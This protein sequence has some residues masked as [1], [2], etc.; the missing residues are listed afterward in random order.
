MRRCWLFRQQRLEVPARPTG[1]LR[2]RS[3]VRPLKPSFMPANHASPKRCHFRLPNRQTHQRRHALKIFIGFAAWENLIDVAHAQVL[4]IPAAKVGGT[5]SPDRSTEDPFHC[6]ATEAFLHASEPCLTEALSFPAAKSTDASTPARFKSS[7]NGW[8]HFS[9]N[10]STAAAN[11]LQ[12][13]FRFWMQVRTA[14]QLFCKKSNNVWLLV[15]P[16]PQ[17]L[18]QLACECVL[19]SKLLFMSGNVEL[20]PGPTKED[21]SLFNKELLQLVK[22]LHDKFDSKHQEVMTALS[23]VKE[24]QYSMEQRIADIDN[25]LSAVEQ[26]IRTSEGQQGES[27]VPQVVVLNQRLNEFEDRSRRENLIFHG[28]ADSAAETWA[29]SEEKIC[30]VLNSALGM[31]LNKSDDRISRAHRLGRFIPNKSRPIIVR[32][33]SSK[34]RETILSSKSKL[35]TTGVS[36]SEDFC[37]ATRAVR[38]KLYDFGKESGQFF[39][40]KYNKLYINKKCYIYSP[41]NDSVCELHLGN[42][43]CTVELSSTATNHHSDASFS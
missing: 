11:M 36:V 29:Q 41:E 1:R 15:L 18:F 12:T 31:N 24:A 3:T 33:L 38:T 28:V 5:S 37:K 27:L 25:R 13:H 23:E 43:P 14:P 2:T 6:E 32:F 19:V 8:R 7:W 42:V 10:G 21:P 16:C 9:G 39:T 26:C 20:N 22:S 30:S 35:K 4:A 34:L 40:V 17:V